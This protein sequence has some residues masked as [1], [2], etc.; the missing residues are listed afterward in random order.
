MQLI[1][2][3]AQGLVIRRGKQGEY[4][5]QTFMF[6]NFCWLFCHVVL[7][8]VRWVVRFAAHDQ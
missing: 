3:T 5:V 7:L 8:R 2:F 6:L 1:E 4:P